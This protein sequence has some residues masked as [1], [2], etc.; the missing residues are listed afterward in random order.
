M[1]VVT[2]GFLRAFHCQPNATSAV[3][4]LA[5][6]VQQIADDLREDRESPI[7]PTLQILLSKLWEE[8]IADNR[9]A[10]AFD[11]AQQD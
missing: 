1:F 10:P 9:S 3:G 5:S 4:E 6:V 2:G 8:A 7:A 11:V